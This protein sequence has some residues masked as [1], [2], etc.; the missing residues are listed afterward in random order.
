MPRQRFTVTFH[1]A[2]AVGLPRWPSYA[3]VGY[4]AGRR[5]WPE[6]DSWTDL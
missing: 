3:V 6:L 2:L 1:A 5:T 4:R